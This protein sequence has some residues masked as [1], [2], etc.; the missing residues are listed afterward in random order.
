ME[1]E[2]KMYTKLLSRRHIGNGPFGRPRNKE[3]YNSILKGSYYSVL[4]RNLRFI[5]FELCFNFM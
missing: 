2:I 3:N 4:L 5:N 1:R